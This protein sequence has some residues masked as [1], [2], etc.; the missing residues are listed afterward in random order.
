[1]AV[2]SKFNFK[3]KE[4]V[5]FAMSGEAGEVIGRAQFTYANPE[6][7]VRYLSSDGRQQEDWIPEDAL[8][9]A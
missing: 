3:L 9:I 1:M 8:V 7:R 6:Y 4:K 5:K 2:K